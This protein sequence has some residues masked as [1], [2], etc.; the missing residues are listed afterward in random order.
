MLWAGRRAESKRPSLLRN[1][2]AN[3]LFVSKKLN[4]RSKVA[5]PKRRIHEQSPRNGDRFR[6][7]LPIVQKGGLPSCRIFERVGRQEAYSVLNRKSEA[8]VVVRIPIN[9]HD[10]R[11]LFPEVVESIMDK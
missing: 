6:E 3:V 4:C 2:Y 1:T 7:H 9:K 11:T 8:T 10:V 5:S